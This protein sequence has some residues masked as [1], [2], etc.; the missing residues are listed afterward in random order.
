MQK[1]RELYARHQL[2]ELEH[3]V[4]GADRRDGYAHR[5]IAHPNGRFQ[6]HHRAIMGILVG[7]F[8]VEVL[9]SR[10]FLPGVGEYRPRIEIVGTRENALMAE[11]VYHFLLR[12][13]EWLTDQAGLRGAYAR[14]SY[15]LGLLTA[16]VKSSRR[17][18]RRWFRKKRRPLLGARSPG[19]WR[20]S[21]R[22][23]GSRSIY[24]K[25]IRG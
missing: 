20:F 19:P 5:V 23:R 1:V 4:P 9:T 8:F 25:F 17:R 14:R 22:T 6:A 3:P 24:P 15:R 11:Y 13:V 7:H 16:S 21:S 2:E 18:R 10:D 12:E